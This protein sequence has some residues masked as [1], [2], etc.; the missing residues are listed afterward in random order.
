MA[1]GTTLVKLLDDLRAETRVSL[2]PA[3]NAQARDTQIKLLQRV[4]EWLWDDFDW[5]ILRV[6][7]I[8]PLLAGQRYYDTPADLDIDRIT[9]MEVRHDQVYC[10]LKAGIDAEHYAAYDSDLGERQWPPQRWKI[11]ENEQVEIW[12][13]PD[14][15]A[16]PLTLEGNL[17]ITGIRK[18]KPLV[19]DGD[20]ADLDDRLIVLYAA[21]EYLA[22]KGADDAKLKLDQA[23]KRY[24]KLR[25]QQTPRKKFSLFGIG[26]PSRIERVPIAVYN[27]TS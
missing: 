12:P 1:R 4:Q 20:R 2:N 14:T 5:P 13:I 16:D 25:G 3:H 24:G 10:A 8:V 7:R 22:A 15:N 17:K 19:A 9:K 26:Q 21:A 18:L 23:N 11:T 27:K 6:E